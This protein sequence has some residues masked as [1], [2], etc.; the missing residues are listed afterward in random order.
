[1]SDVVNDRWE[2]QN[3]AADPRL[4]GLRAKLHALYE[5]LSDCAGAECRVT[6]YGDHWDS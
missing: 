1:V 2:L 6:G 5:R 3:R 4:G